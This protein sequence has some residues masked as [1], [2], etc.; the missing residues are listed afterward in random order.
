MDSFLAFPAL[1]GE[2]RI[3]STFWAVDMALGML[4]AGSALAKRKRR[5]RFAPKTRIPN[6]LAMVRAKE[7][8]AGQERCDGLLGVMNGIAVG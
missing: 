3:G 4:K 5:A 1:S 7:R 8:K 6:A 2:G